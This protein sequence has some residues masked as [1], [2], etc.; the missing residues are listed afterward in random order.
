[1]T[2]E[3]VVSVRV[4]ARVWIV[5]PAVNTVATSPNAAPMAAVAAAAERPKSSWGTSITMTPAKP[6]RTA[7]QRKMRT[8]S[9]RKIADRA[10]VMSGER[11]EIAV[12]STSGRH[13]NA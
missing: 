13:A 4:S 7:D 2:I 8:R 10:T 12:A 5:E 11:E 6:I 3:D 9:L 1:M